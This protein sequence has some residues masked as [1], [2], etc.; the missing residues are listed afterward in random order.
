L[1]NLIDNAIKYS[2]SGTSVQVQARQEHG[3]AIIEVKDQGPGIPDAELPKIWSRL[4]RGDRSRS[5]RGLGLGLSLVK[6]IAH[7]HGGNA[8]VVSNPS[9]GSVFTLKI[10]LTSRKIS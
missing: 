4:Y 2:A 3:F 8:E 5:S 1:S 10:P 7:A 6:A 9:G